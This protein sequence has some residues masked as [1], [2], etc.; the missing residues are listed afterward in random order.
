M[1]SVFQN[2]LYVLKKFKT[3][4]IINILGLS[5]AL[6]VFF[7]VLMEVHYDFTFDRGYAHPERIYHLTIYDTEQGSARNQVINFRIPAQIRNRIPEIEDYCLISYEHETDFDIMNDKGVSEL[8]KINYTRSTRGFWKVFSPEILLGDTTDIFSSPGYAIISEKTARRLFGS[9]N[10][11][12]RYIKSHYSEDQM[13]IRAVYRDFPDNSSLTNGLYG[14]LPDNGGG[15]WNYLA[16]FLIHPRNIQ[17]VSETVNEKINT[18]DFLKEQNV[19]QNT[20]FQLAPLNELYLHAAGFDG[21]RINTTIALLIIGILTLFIAFVNFVNL[22]LAMAPSR[23]RSITIRRIFGINKTALKLTVSTESILFSA[24]ALVLAFTGVYFLKGSALAHEMFVSGLSFRSHSLLLTIASVAVLLIAFVIGIYTM[25]HTTAVD[26]TEVLKDSFHLGIQGIKLRNILIVFQFTTAIAL[27][28]IATFIQKQNSFMRNYDWGMPKENIVFLPL[29]GLDRSAES[30][31][32]ELLR[33]P[34]ITDYC[35]ISSLPGRVGMNWGRIFEGKQVNLFLW[36]VDTR[37]FD[38]FDVNIMAGH[39]PEYADSTVTQI[40]VNETF[41]KNYDFDTDIMGKDFPAGGIPGRIQATAADVNFQ[42]LHLPIQPMAFAVFDQK[43]FLNYFMVKLSGND[44][45]GAIG[46]MEQ[47][48]KQFSNEDFD[49]HFLDQNM[50]MLYTKEINMA[51]LITLF[52]LV[53]ILIAVMGVYGLIL[54][55]TKYKTKEIAIRKIN[56]SAITEIMLMLNRTVL[57]QLGAAFIIAIPI[58]YVV[59]SKWLENFAYKT[60][61]YWWVFLF[62]GILV[63]LITIITVSWQSYKAA[64]ANP[65][66]AIKTE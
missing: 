49:M 55:N 61:M 12:G 66:E 3:A 32:Q 13:T 28:C 11:I 1:K 2:F 59:V 45:R 63:F 25:R 60:P 53:I 57:I 48:W 21:K 26:D 38:F 20:V 42:S 15:G 22:S 46:H 65:V 29:S 18:A 41:L 62:S 17:T 40:V 5:V 19:R 24:V 23:V 7:V 30:F 39:K 54:F 50:D 51:K 58:S 16:Y 52:G 44:I 4:S 56:G 9:E 47:T 35:L 8:H 14:F 27:I 6:T 36:L 10:P 31:G 43:Q 33:D 64:V 37:F 34:R